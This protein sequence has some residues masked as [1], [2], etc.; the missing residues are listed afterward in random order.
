MGETKMAQPADEPPTRVAGYREELEKFKALSGEV[1]RSTELSKGEIEALRRKL[2]VQALQL[3]RVRR[4]AMLTL[5]RRR[6]GVAKH[7]EHVYAA[8]TQAAAVQDHALAVRASLS[9]IDGSLRQLQ[10]IDHHL[11]VPEAEFDEK[12]P[13]PADEAESRSARLRRRIQY[14]IDVATEKAAQLQECTRE[15][16]SLSNALKSYKRFFHAAMA[17]LE[18][19]VDKIAKAHAAVD[20]PASAREGL[21]PGYLPIALYRTQQC[22]SRYLGDDN[23]AVQGSVQ[24][25]V[26]F[27]KNGQH[28]PKN[29]VSTE[30][31][32]L[33]VEAKLRRGSPQGEDPPGIRF[34]YRPNTQT[35]VAEADQFDPSVLLAVSPCSVEHP[36]LFY[37]GGLVT[38][39]TAPWVDDLCGLGSSS[40][41][42]GGPTDTPETQPPAPAAPAKDA[43][44][45]DVDEFAN[46]GE[47]SGEAPAK[48]VAVSGHN[49]ELSVV[50]ESVEKA[51]DVLSSVVEALFREIAHRRD[52]SASFALL[53]NKASMASSNL[54]SV[55]DRY[56]P[57]HPA[58]RLSVT[59]IKLEPA[60]D[61]SDKKDRKKTLS[62]LLA[63]VDASSDALPKALTYRLEA[64]G[65]SYKVQGYV[66]SGYPAV[67]PTFKLR[68]RRK[69]D[70]PDTEKVEL[71]L[72]AAL[73]AVAAPF[74]ALTAAPPSIPSVQVC[75]TSSRD[76]KKR[77]KHESSLAAAAQ[78][79]PESAGVDAGIVAEAQ[80]YFSR[81]INR[82][83]VGETP[84]QKKG[85]MLMRQ[86]LF[87]IY[88]V[89]ALQPYT[90]HKGVG[91]VWNAPE[92]RADDAW[93]SL[94]E[95]NLFR[96][97][98]HAGTPLYRG[99][100]LQLPLHWNAKHLQWTYTPE[101][102]FHIDEADEAA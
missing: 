20:G 102:E 52:L 22:L 33:R 88:F 10:D 57:S 58:P 21:T 51:C 81:F 89:E 64:D 98:Q 37:A 55:I 92:V 35:V 18:G 56:L 8:Q 19:L 94:H 31:H 97:R 76:A 16:L 85:H 11:A 3:R 45:A 69:E 80:A 77:K 87:S 25:A 29:A 78:K 62:S 101:Q 100:E 48:E 4:G 13:L 83:V 32:P 72:P 68:I 75:L 24:A 17:P 34:Y 95:P 73:R 6:A 70:D 50:E 41:F 7:A 79:D 39:V 12:R 27:V 28:L 9:A 74:E 1:L 44:M 54:S 66:P 67:P 90:R 46:L 42:G 26:L 23:V 59:E 91:V 40:N 65:V 71:H 99:L 2:A 82:T 86:V 63:Q 84:A 14:E 53:R 60:A 49:G 36:G 5:E 93:L 15:R 47:D 38:G 30:L 96:I 61:S 43:V